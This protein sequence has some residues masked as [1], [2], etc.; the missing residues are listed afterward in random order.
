M[1]RYGLREP[2]RQQLFEMMRERVEGS[3]YVAPEP[4]TEE[5]IRQALEQPFVPERFIH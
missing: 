2:Y 4:I 3:Q 5:E 1:R